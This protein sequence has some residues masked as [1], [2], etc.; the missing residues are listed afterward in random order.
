MIRFDT[1]RDTQLHPRTLRCASPHTMRIDSKKAYTAREAATLL[2]ITEATVKR[3]L[4]EGS[5]KGVQV[6]PSKRWHVTGAEISRL[7]TLWK[8]DLISR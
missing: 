6:G 1:E 3:R 2:G 5:I 4:R 7:R 8:L